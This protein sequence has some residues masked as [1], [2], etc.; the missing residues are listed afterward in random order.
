MVTVTTWARDMS[1][2]L[3]ENAILQYPSM[4]S[5][6]RNSWFAGDCE[7]L[8]VAHLNVLEVVQHVAQGRTGR[9]RGSGCLVEW[10]G[11]KYWGL[12]HSCFS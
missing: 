12:R 9:L 1:T 2:K 11:Q 7:M 3:G 4:R 5:Q 6:L 10:Q 8:W